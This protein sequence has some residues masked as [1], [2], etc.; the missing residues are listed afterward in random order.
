MICLVHESIFSNVAEEDLGNEINSKNLKFY[1]TQDIGN[2]EK[3][4]IIQ[5]LNSDYLARGP[6][7]QFELS[8]GNFVVAMGI[9]SE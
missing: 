8:L 7:I 4:A 3:E 9:S 6:K 1:S 5:V 2:D